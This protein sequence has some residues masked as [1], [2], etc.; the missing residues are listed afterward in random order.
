MLFIII[1]FGIYFYLSICYSSR[2]FISKC[3]Y[4]AYKTI[5]FLTYSRVRM[6]YD[7]PIQALFG[8]ARARRS[9]PTPLTKPVRTSYLQVVEEENTADIP[10]LETIHDLIL[11]PFTLE[12]DRSSIGM[13]QK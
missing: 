6:S 1:I 7:S 9:I 3:T 10:T 8:A 13:Q 4:L 12:T 5:F 2:S 11:R